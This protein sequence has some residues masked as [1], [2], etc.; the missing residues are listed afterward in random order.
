MYTKY[1]SGGGISNWAYVPITIPEYTEEQKQRDL[2]HIRR[3]CRGVSTGF[4][5]NYTSGRHNSSSKNVGRGNK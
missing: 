3:V 1:K 4:C 2:E 5:S